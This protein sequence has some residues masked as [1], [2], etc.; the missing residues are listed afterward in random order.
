MAVALLTVCEMACSGFGTRR[1]VADNVPNARAQP[2]VGIGKVGSG[3]GPEQL[4]YSSI[5]VHLL[6]QG[7]GV[8]EVVVVAKARGCIDPTLA[9]TPPRISFKI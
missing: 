5:T 3:G 4:C 6:G 8:C 1:N 2:G 7:S 9:K